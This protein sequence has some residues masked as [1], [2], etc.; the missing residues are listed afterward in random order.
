MHYASS[1]RLS[2]AMQEAYTVPA[3]AW[4]N[5]RGHVY[6]DI[7]CQPEYNS[8]RKNKKG[9]KGELRPPPGEGDWVHPCR[10]TV[11]VHCLKKEREPVP[12][13]EPSHASSSVNTCC[14]QSN[15]AFKVTSKGARGVEGTPVPR[16][17]KFEAKVPTNIPKN[18]FSQKT[19]TWYF[20]Y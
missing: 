12:V 20:S 5:C 1:H 15:P 14:I 2:S 7:C 16:G 13:H 11:S 8:P 9:K 17:R 10:G 4:P 6:L 3:A 19:Q 18:E